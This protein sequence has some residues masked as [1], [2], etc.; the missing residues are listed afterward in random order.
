ML[1]GVVVFLV[2]TRE[3]PSETLIGTLLGFAAVF[4]GVPLVMPG[5]KK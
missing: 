2:V 5:A 4:I 1:V 3:Q